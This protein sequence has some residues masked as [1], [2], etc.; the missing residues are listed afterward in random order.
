MPKV[1]NLNDATYKLQ[2]M[3]I[4]DNSL[5]RG[6]IYVLTPANEKDMFPNIILPGVYPL[7]NVP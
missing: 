7:R 1:N 5:N 4:G 6:P 3:K 2:G